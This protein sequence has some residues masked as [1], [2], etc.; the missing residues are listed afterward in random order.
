MDRGEYTSAARHA[1]RSLKA[2]GRGPW[3]GRLIED[4]DKVAAFLAEKSLRILR[5]LSPAA[6]SSV[7]RVSDRPQSIKS[8]WLVAIGRP[9]VAVKKLC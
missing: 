2:T 7:L 8:D 1:L 6:Q 3:I 9:L 4:D 5:R